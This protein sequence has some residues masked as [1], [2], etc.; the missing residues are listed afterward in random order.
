MSIPA[1]L[2]NLTFGDRCFLAFGF[3]LNQSM[4]KV[5]LPAGLQSLCPG[6]DFSLCM[7]MV[8]LPAGLQG[9]GWPAEPQLWRRL[10]SE[11]EKVNLPAGFLSL[12][13]E[14]TS[15]CVFFLDGP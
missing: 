8:D 1:G 9:L 14:S 15:A 13:P 12:E 4:V 2:Q 6:F 7:E 5:H 3:G 11:M 10:Q